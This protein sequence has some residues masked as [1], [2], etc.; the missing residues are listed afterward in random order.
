MAKNT[1]FDVLS[2]PPVP[3]ENRP[4]KIFFN[5][6]DYEEEEYLRSNGYSPTILFTMPRNTHVEQIDYLLAKCQAMEEGTI[7]FSRDQRLALV[8]QMQAFGLLDKKGQMLN[9]NCNVD[10]ET[11]QSIL[12]WSKSRH[13]LAGNSTVQGVPQ[14]KGKDG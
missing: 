13:T 2:L 1:E 11:L 6:L 8:S 10:G 7:P 3:E 12:G 14:L 5:A 4:R 9:L